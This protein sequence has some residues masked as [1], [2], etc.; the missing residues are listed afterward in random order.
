MTIAAACPAATVSVA[1][2]VVIPAVAQDP[3]SS[4]NEGATKQANFTVV[5]QVTIEGAPTK[6]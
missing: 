2:T 4:R 1:S 3:L 5:T 6:R